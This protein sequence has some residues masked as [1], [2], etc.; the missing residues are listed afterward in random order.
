MIKRLISMLLCMLMV[1]PAFAGCS[2]YDP[3][4]DVGETLNMYLENEVYDFDPAYA[5]RSKE[6]LQISKLLFSTLFY[7]DENGKLK[8]NLVKNYEIEEDEDQGIYRITLELKNTSWSDGNTVNAKDILFAW[9]R[10]LNPSTVSDA[11]VLLYEIRNAYDAKNGNCSVDDIGVY[12]IDQS[13]LQIDFDQPI[14]FEDFLYNLASPCLAPVRE[15]V[16]ADNPNW[17]KRPGFIVCSG[18]FVLREVEYGKSLTLERNTYYMR[19]KD[20]DSIKKFVTPYRIVVDYSKS[21]KEQL[22][23]YKNGDI[24]YVGNISLDSRSEYKN[25]AE[26]Y[27]SLSTLS[28][29]FNLNNEIF[30][31]AETRKA[32]SD[33]IDRSAIADMLVFAEEATA[34]VPY[35]VFEATK[36]K[37]NFRDVGGDYLSKTAS[38]DL[39]SFSGSFSISVADNEED[40]AVAEI[41]K[42]SW[43]KLGFDVEIIKLSTSATDVILQGEESPTKEFVNDDYHAALVNRSF[44]VILTD[45]SALNTDAFSM[46]APF[47]S[48]YSG[49]NITFTVDS[50][51]EAVNI[52]GYNSEEYN[53]LIDSAFAEKNV[54]KRA[55]ILHEAEKM[56]MNDLPVCPIVF[57]KEAVLMSGIKG[58]DVDYFGYNDFTD[59][60]SK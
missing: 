41:L 2:S 54:S 34:L 1:L 21:A 53:N 38:N 44:D 28:A 27:N 56:L 50:F 20:K 52:T 6:A 14:D 33:A 30:A 25:K 57:I 60:K 32:L 42:K 37:K 29:Y 40:L 58:I 51:E 7:V 49:R 35:G 13:T 55:S 22:E 15:N 5:Y 45:I 18:P 26:V 19:N 3:D 39:G 17:A 31:N 47:A 4:E 46:L 48:A 8:K 36:A 43:E 24:S 59:L 23:A 11:A 16:V 12:A 9:K 10:L